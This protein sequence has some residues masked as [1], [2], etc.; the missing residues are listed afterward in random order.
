MAPIATVIFLPIGER[1]PPK[2]T[3]AAE[4]TVSQSQLLNRG[5]M[6]D[7][8][9]LL[10]G[11]R[12]VQEF[13]KGE[14]F[15]LWS[16]GV[17]GEVPV[18]EDRTATKVELVVSTLAEPQGKFT[19]GALGRAITELAEADKAEGDLPAIVYWDETETKRGLQPAVV[20]QAVRQYEA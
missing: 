10:G 20:I 4:E 18:G 11:K 3:P 1:M 14:N 9:R 7:R 12:L 13:E 19:V 15:I 6:W 16:L 17:V 5:G 2:A 8:Q